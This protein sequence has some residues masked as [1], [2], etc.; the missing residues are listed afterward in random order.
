[1]SYFPFGLEAR[2]LAKR[3]SRL[4]WLLGTLSLW[5]AT[6]LPGHAVPSYARQTGE[7]CGAC[8]IGGFGPQLTAHGLKFKLNAYAESDG[9]SGHVPLSAMLVGSY[10]KTKKDQSGD[11]GPYQGPNDN[12]VVQEV[13]AFLAGGLTDHIGTFVQA[14]YS[15]IERKLALDNVDVRYAQP[16]QLAG[17]E[18]IVGITFNNNPTVTDLF[19]SVPAWR[20]PYMA[21]DL[22]P[23]PIASPVIDGG[24]EQQVGGVSVYG[25]WNDSI[26]AE[27]GGYHTFSRGFLENM[28]V[29]ANDDPLDK[30]SGVSPYWRLTYF[31]DLHSQAWQ[32]G[33]FGFDPNIQLDGGP[34]EKDRYRD[35]GI[36][37]SY[38][39]LGNRQHVFTVNT[40]YIYESRHLDG[41]YAAGD[42]ENSSGH[43]NRV[44]LS[45]S[46]YYDRTLGL[47]A[48]VFNIGGSSDNVLY[49]PEPDSG[50]RNGKPD[51]SGYI[52]QAD[53]TPFGKESSWGSPW[54]NLRAGLQYT[55]YTKF[56][57]ASTNYD[58]YGRDA[59]DNNT[60]FAFIWTAF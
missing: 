44:D 9:K 11:A 19:N 24:L 17:E 35:Y 6:T 13:S 25:M 58:G 47:T 59:K 38:Q 27:V 48:G 21:S 26:Y 30:T 55:G 54:A 15:G 18:A 2:H 36:D 10:T 45:G 4:V 39:F 34:S 7:E 16:V 49:G 5:A 28:N 14:T 8:H 1:M 56:N 43:V 60:V 46:Y 32:V 51:I 50:S 57:G 23:G 40:A 33:V 31:K 12:A 22:T 37:A 53:F 42:A 20:F 3:R 41:T 29:I 52:L